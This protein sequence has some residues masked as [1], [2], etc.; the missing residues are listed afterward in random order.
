[1]SSRIAAVLGFFVASQSLLASAETLALK[2]WGIDEE[3][4]R[5]KIVREGSRLVSVDL[6]GPVTKFGYEPGFIGST[7][8]TKTVKGAGSLVV[9]IFGG[10]VSNCSARATSQSPMS[11]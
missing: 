8:E 11:A 9:D 3:S 6:R 10:E 7:S 2:G 1:M 5:V 4:C